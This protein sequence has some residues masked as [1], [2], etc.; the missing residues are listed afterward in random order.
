MF[1]LVCTSIP[2]LPSTWNWKKTVGSRWTC[3]GVRVPRTLDY[4]KRKLKSAL[5]CTVWSQCTPIPDRRTDK[6]HGN[7]ATIRSNKYIVRQ[8]CTM[9][10][11]LPLITHNTW[12][13]SCLLLWN[14]KQ[15]I[16]NY[17]DDTCSLMKC[18]YGLE[19]PHD[20]ED[21]VY[22]WLETRL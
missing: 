16:V 22:N 2:H 3:F 15:Q 18:E 10:W 13:I 21:Y 4:P 14:D 8:K 6:H 19:S 7:S 5:K 17:V 20:V 9:C 11:P 12:Q 1:R